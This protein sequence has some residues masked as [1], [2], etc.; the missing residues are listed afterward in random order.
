VTFLLEKEMKFFNVL[1]CSDENKLNIQ[2]ITSLLKGME[3]QVFE[4]GNHIIKNNERFKQIYL[5]KNGPVQVFDGNYNYL[6]ELENASFFG[7]YNILFG[8]TNTLY[9]RISKS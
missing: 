5:I 7:E 6:F 4:K 8:L 1:F 3:T 2:T 9:Y